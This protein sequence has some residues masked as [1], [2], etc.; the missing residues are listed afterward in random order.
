MKHSRRRQRLLGGALAGGL[1]GIVSGALIATAAPKVNEQGEPDGDVRSIVDAGHVPPFL[2]LP[3]ERV[4]LRYAI[5]CPAP[6]DAPFSG[7]PCDGGGDVYIR[8]GTS[9]AFTRLPLR[10]TDDSTDGRYAV[11]VPAAIASSRDGFTYF[12]VLRDEV[13]GASMTLP[14]GGADAPQRSV[15]LAAAVTVRLG[16]HRFGFV[17][18]RDARVVEAAW[19]AGV[20]ELGLGGSPGGLRIGPSSFDVASDGAVV[21]LDGANSRLERW[22]H[23]TA[24]VVHADLDGPIADMALAPDGT[25][26]V[27]GGR[28]RVPSLRHLGRDGRLLAAEATVERTWSQ[29]RLGPDGPVVQQEPSEQWLRAAPGLTRSE[30][31]R[32]GRAGRRVADGSEIVVLRTGVGELRLARIVG[33]RVRNAWRIVSETP[34]GEVQLAEPHGDRVIAVVKTYS[35][36]ADEFLVLVLGRNGLVDRFSVPPAEWAAGAPLARFRLSGPSLYHLGS[37]PEGAFV[38]RYDL[39]VT[40]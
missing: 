18:P 19:G 31:V 12:A 30:K 35:D 37:T 6:G 39:E 22:E 36:S 3:G 38:D 10:R 11:D 1:A 14:A 15:P 7:A 17:R 13:T 16:P 2:T 23:G 29:L 26:Y 27:V 25:T 9:G 8:A 21:L 28:G 40:R 34:L 32:S 33:G 20:G 4:T 24:S 5:V